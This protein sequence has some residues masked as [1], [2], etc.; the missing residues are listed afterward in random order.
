MTSAE[1]IFAALELLEPDRVPIMESVIDERV[2]RA[3][4]PDTFESGEFAVRIGLDAVTAGL[5]FNRRDETSNGHYDEWGVYYRNSP[6]ALFHPVKGPV[7]TMAD[8]ETWSPP[9]P[10]APWRLGTLPD[11]IARYKG[12]KAIVL[13]H[14]AAF[15]WS[16]YV[17]GLD[18]LLLSFAADP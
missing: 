12:E 10:D 14:R 16:A 18:N 9:D 6:E 13:H 1:R 15:M 7:E 2:R 17:T 5:E 11:L 8:L 4:Y 3:I